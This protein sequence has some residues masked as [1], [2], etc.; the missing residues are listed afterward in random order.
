MSTTTK[1]GTTVTQNG[2]PFIIGTFKSGKLH[3]FDIVL[4]KNQSKALQAITAT[5]GDYTL[6]HKSMGH[7]HQHMI[8]HL[9]NN[10]EGGPHQTTNAPTSACEGCKKGK[11]K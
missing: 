3:T 4:A 1:Q 10:M 8:K 6:W 5:L 7:A 9:R 11:P 2:A